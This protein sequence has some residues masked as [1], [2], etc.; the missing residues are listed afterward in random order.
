MAI[1][2]VDTGS[3]SMRTVV[4]AENGDVLFLAQQEYSMDLGPDGRATM[5]AEVFEQTLESLSRQA[6]AY[7]LKEKNVSLRGI[8]LTSQRSSVLAVD[9]DGRPLYP[10][11]MWYDKRSAPLCEAINEQMGQEIYAR[12]GMRLTPVASAPKMRWLHEH[13]PA[14]YEKAYKLIGIHDYLLFLLTGNFVTDASLASRSSLMDI[15]SFT[16]SPQLCTLFGV[17]V[18][19][20]CT[21][22]PPGS[23]AGKLTASFAEKTGLPAGIPVISAGG[24]QQCCVLGQGLAGPGALSVN[25]GS[26]SYIT[27]AAEKPVFDSHMEVG[28][29]AHCVPGKWVC[30]ASNMSSGTAYRWFFETFYGIDGAS[31][32]KAMDE[33]IA[34]RPACTGGVICLPDFAGRGCPGIDPQA[35]GV[36]FNVGLDSTRADFARALLEGIACDIAE[37]AAYLGNMGV[38][39][40][41]VLSTGGL[42]KFSVFNQ[43]T[44]D[45][46]GRPVQVR[47]QRETT[48]FGALVGTLVSLGD[49]SSPQAFFAQ[50]AVE[51]QVFEPKREEMEIYAE[52]LEQ[53]R[54]YKEKMHR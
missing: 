1:L 33:E 45:L 54:Q 51:S 30:E 17:D 6:V 16:W 35:R 44:A 9:R 13:E 46:L 23:Q 50:Y 42:T 47:R 32:L 41:P 7:L 53:R 52:L 48:A 49:F 14:I 10:I 39:D 11:L 28:L 40:G 18:E 22:L 4:F 21:L 15:R 20:L 19:K 43:V 36:F 8:A 12:S 29:N 5:R 24:D 25:S 26:A 3:S 27:A 34:A 2:V 38:G 37:A 31:S